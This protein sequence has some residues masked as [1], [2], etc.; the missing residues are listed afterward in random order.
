MRSLCA[1]LALA[2]LTLLPAACNFP[3]RGTTSTA[4]ARNLITTPTLR[5][6]DETSTMPPTL[7][8]P[9]ATPTPLSTSTPQVSPTQAPP[10]P[11]DWITYRNPEFGFEVRHPAQVTQTSP[12]PG[13]IRIDLPIQPGTNLVEKYLQ[14]DIRTEGEECISPL[15]IGYAPGALEEERLLVNGSEF[16]KQSGSEG[17]AGNYYDWIGYSTIRGDACISLTFVLHSLDPFNF[18]T[19]PPTFD[20]QSESAIFELIMDSFNW[21]P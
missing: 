17:A 9:S 16:L 14:I 12:Q 1:L 20:A 18:E 19:P 3:A 10:V 6:P 11:A 7:L 21:L 2:C 5:L 8:P 13:Q 15:A 4:E